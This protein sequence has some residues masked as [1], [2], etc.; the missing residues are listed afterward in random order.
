MTALPLHPVVNPFPVVATILAAGCL[1]AGAARPLHERGEWVLRGL[2]LLSVALLAMP[3]VAWTGR[4]WAV[5]AGLW[6]PRHG[7][8]GLLLAH[9]LGA[10]A[11]TV[12]MVLAARLAQAYRRRRVGL[13]PVLAL[14]LA[15]ALATGITAHLGGRIAFGE[16]EA[17]QAGP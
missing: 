13:W 3:A 6:P 2:L 10:L 16:P 7:P 14:A 12:L 9:V 4:G 1:S 15:S 5:A 8:G 11:A 17:S